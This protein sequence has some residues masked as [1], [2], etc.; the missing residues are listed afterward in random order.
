[1]LHNTSSISSSSLPF[2]HFFSP[3]SIFN[4]DVGS[5]LDCGRETLQLPTADGG[6]WESHVFMRLVRS[7]HSLLCVML[8]FF[9]CIRPLLFLFH[10]LFPATVPLPVS[11]CPPFY[12]SK[13]SPFASFSR[14][15]SLAS[16]FFL[17]PLRFL[18]LTT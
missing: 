8:R 6:V 15:C 2:S 16:F 10:F 3:C 5:D 12:S 13:M 7:T 4:Q 9:L 18:L 17:A 1:M 14:L 11:C